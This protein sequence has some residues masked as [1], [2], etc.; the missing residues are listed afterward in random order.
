[1]RLG[2]LVLAVALAAGCGGGLRVG[3]EIDRPARMPVRAFAHIVVVADE[4]EASRAI[5]ERLIEHLRGGDSRVEL[6]SGA[7]LE[8]L[9]AAGRVARGTIAL[10]VEATLLEE[11]RRAWSRRPILECGAFGC[12]DTPHPRV[13][14]LGAV[15][16]HLT[17]TVAD[18]PSGRP[19]QREEL[20][21][22]EEGTDP[23][24][25]RL[26]ILERLSTDATRLVDAQRET[27]DVEL[28]AVDVREVRD[29]LDA[30]G[31]GLW[32]RGAAALDRFV[33]SPAFGALG[34]EAR[35]RVLYDLGQARRFDP[36]LPPDERHA[37]AA[38]ALRAAIRLDPRPRFSRALDD[39][40]ADRRSGS[41][42][43]AQREA[44]A[45]NFRLARGEDP[46]P[47]PPA[48]YR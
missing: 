39:V 18:G 30:I 23:L 29:A 28:L 10:G 42:L 1:M 7:E 41:L 43:R 5:A 40:A 33:A 13:V 38:E 19:L 4:S 34:A 46:V 3:G 16:G 9:R 26:R 45:H 21:A 36:S 35:A 20:A 11:A 47:E 31:A 2:G 14:E 22:E 6:R 24:G 15:R 32:D 37:R 12:L 25:M 44:R 48:T 8:A 17:L 27:V